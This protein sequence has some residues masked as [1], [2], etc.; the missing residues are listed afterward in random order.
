MAT[1][2]LS[3]SAQTPPSN[4]G[5]PLSAVEI[6]AAVAEIL[7]S[8][9]I[10]DIHTH[11][12]APSFGKL[13]LWGIDELLTYHYL[14]AE[15]FRFSPIRPEAYWELNKEERADLVWK[16]LFVENTPLSESA[17]GV[18]AVLQAFELD[19]SAKSLDSFRQFFRKQNFA[20]HVRR[21]FDL[22]G[23]SDVVMTNDPLDADEAMLWN[24]G[25][26]AGTGFHAALRIDRVLQEDAATSCDRLHIFL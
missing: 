24:A 14:E 1:D 3:A 26:Q 7:A 19:S 23:V 10:V 15:L 21:V 17:R 18:I 9:P 4:S 22:A 6:P 12:F 20:D 11:L 2:L 25:A 8:T 16:P 5:T 13:S